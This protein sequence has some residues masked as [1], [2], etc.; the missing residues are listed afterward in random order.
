[1]VNPV[2]EKSSILPRLNT[3]LPIHPFAGDIE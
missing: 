3:F 2:E 1:M